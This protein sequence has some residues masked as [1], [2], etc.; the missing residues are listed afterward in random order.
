MVINLKKFTA[1]VIASATGL[2][3][4]SALAADAANGAN[5]FKTSICSACHAVTK[6]GT[7]PVGPN[8]FGV[9]GRKAGTLAGYSYSPALKASGITWDEASL[10]KW[11]VSPAT[12]VPNNKMVFA[13]IK[14]QS[15]ADDV[16]AYL[17]TLK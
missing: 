10:A 12:L 13:G 5:V 8:L 3:A 2:G 16:A 4:S 17:S 14:K 7:N 9:V 1:I 6:S 15:D 11:A